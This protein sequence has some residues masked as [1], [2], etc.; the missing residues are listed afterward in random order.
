MSSTSWSRERGPSSLRASC[1]SAF[2][3]A[4]FLFC[5]CGY[6][7]SRYCAGDRAGERQQSGGVLQACSEAY[8]DVRALGDRRRG[9]V[10]QVVA[11]VGSVRQQAQACEGGAQARRSGAAGAGQA[12]LQQREDCRVALD[13]RHRR[14]GERQA[15]GVLAQPARGVQHAQLLAR[16]L[17]ARDAAHHRRTPRL[18]PVARGHCQQQAHQHKE[19][20][21]QQR[22]RRTERGRGCRRWDAGRWSVRGHRAP[23][24]AAAGG[25]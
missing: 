25:A 15:H 3:S 6:M 12:V 2:G 7:G 17:R 20:R 14:A 19:Q 5:R 16:H 9:E 11:R 10:A 23:G 21:L 13:D 18:E 24:A 1:I 8:D 22:W 4:V